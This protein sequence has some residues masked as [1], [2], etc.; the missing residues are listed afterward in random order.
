MT[1]GKASEDLRYLKSVSLHLLLFGYELPG[2]ANTSWLIVFQ[3]LD[4][5]CHSAHD[6][7]RR[8]PIASLLSHST[9]CNDVSGVE[10]DRNEKNVCIKL[11]SNSCIGDLHKC[12]LASGISNMICPD[13]RTEKMLQATLHSYKQFWCCVLCLQRQFLSLHRR[14]YTS[15]AAARKVRSPSRTQNFRLLVIEIQVLQ[16]G[17]WGL[18]SIVL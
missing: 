17:C 9:I 8:T 5:D 10:T 18:S 4:A 13:T 3:V 12:G 14:T 2:T 16:Q 1:A 11:I 15:L 6:A 7:L